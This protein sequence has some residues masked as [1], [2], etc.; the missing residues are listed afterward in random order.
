MNTHTPPHTDGE[1]D[2]PSAEAMLAGTLALM[3]GHAQSACPRQ[4]CLMSEKI[5]SNLAQMAQH[6]GFSANF[7]AVTERIRP[8]WAL[9]TQ[10]DGTF[11]RGATST[12][13]ELQTLWCNTA[14]RLQ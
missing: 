3:T 13:L 11:T 7:Q 5:V 1:Y 8:I 4:R 12:Q 14:R 2:M 9:L 10:A 6:P